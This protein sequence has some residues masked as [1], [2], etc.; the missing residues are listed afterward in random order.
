MAK[1]EKSFKDRVMAF[2]TQ[3]AKA[4]D[5]EEKTDLGKAMV[6]GLLGLLIRSALA[7]VLLAIGIGVFGIAIG[8][9]FGAGALGGMMGSN[10][11]VLI[12]ILVFV[13]G[14]IGGFIGL[15]VM[16]LW[17]HLWAYIFGAR[18]GLGQTVK[19]AFYANTPDYALGWIPMVSIAT[20]IWSLV[21]FGV[22]L[23]RLQKL[24]TGKAA[25]AVIIGVVL[26]LILYM[27]AVGS[28]ATQLPIAP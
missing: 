16:G 28:L 26:P 24:P 17:I 20:S 14:V 11:G 18:Q 10:L 5:A 23:T 22:G 15:L 12:G 27:V 21:L 9:L 8:G 13:V 6:Y 3:P 2:I 1:G 7:A 4:F 25:A 19:T